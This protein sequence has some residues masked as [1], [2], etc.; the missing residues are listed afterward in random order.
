MPLMVMFDPARPNYGRDSNML[1]HMEEIR[2]QLPPNSGNR[3]VALL[4]IYMGNHELSDDKDFGTIPE[5]YV[6][7]L[8][9]FHPS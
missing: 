2:A 6:V 9:G 4:L 8:L 7:R 1:R 3:T 5:Q